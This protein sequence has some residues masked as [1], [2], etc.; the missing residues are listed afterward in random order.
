MSGCVWGLNGVTAQNH[1]PLEIA[2]GER[3]EIVFRNK[4]MMSHPMH[5]HGHAFQVVEIDGR[6]FSG[7]RRDTVHVRPTA[8]R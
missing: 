5:L 4:A 2:A 7:A 1:P 6:R 3:V 8:P